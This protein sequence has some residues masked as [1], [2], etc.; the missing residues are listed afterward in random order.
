[1]RSCL[2]AVLA[3]IPVLA[4]S[5][6]AATADPAAALPA[7]AALL[8]LQRHGSVERHTADNLW[9]RID[10]E[11]ELYRVYGL[12]ASAHALYEDPG[13]PERRID[14]SVFAFADPL[15]AFG[16]FAS[17]RPPECEAVQPLGNGGCTGD[18]Q[19]FFWHG[20]LFV[21]ADAAGPAASRPA[22]LRKA[23]ATAAALLGSPPPR[24]KPLRAFSRIAE[25][26]TIRYQPQHLLGR[27]ML[28]PGLEGVAGGIPIFVST[29]AGAGERVAAT[30]EAYAGVLEGAA[31]DGRNGLLILSGRDPDL[32]PVTIVGGRHGLSGARSAAGAPGVQQLLE[33]LAAPGG[34]PAPE[35]AW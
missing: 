29:S 35:G 24:P 14:L 8:P 17:F 23:L 15:G 3:L 20:D 34:G 31:R 11:A 1:M 5:V 7:A 26:R 22:D 32:G 19:G 6:Q 10:G 4:A 13:Q 21:L 30:L 27:A 2:Q 18:Y 33:A 9:E 12:E 16:L 28:P 25:T